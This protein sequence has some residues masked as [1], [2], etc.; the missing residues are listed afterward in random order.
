MNQT[1]VATFTS[2]KD[3]EE[4]VRLLHKEGLPLERF[5]IA[6]TGFNAERQVVGF[7][8]TG[9]V[10]KQGFAR[11]TFAGAELGGLF[12]LLTGAGLFFVPGVGPLLALGGMLVSALSAAATGTLAGAAFGTVAGGLMALGLP[13]N[14][15]LKYETS[16]RSG[17]FLMVTQ[18]TP[19][20]IE[21]VRSLMSHTSATDVEVTSTL[22]AGLARLNTIMSVFAAEAKAARAALQTD[23][24]DQNAA[25][26]AAVEAALVQLRAQ[27]DQAEAQLNETVEDEPSIQAAAEQ[28]RIDLGQARDKLKLAGEQADSGASAQAMIRIEEAEQ[29]LDEAH[30]RLESRLDQSAGGGQQSAPVTPIVPAPQ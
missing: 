15:A 17:N 27:I 25:S 2:N 4:A 22:E 8:Q 21:Q 5:S 30:S 3:A 19:A 13:Q 23:M 10:I 11:G 14:Y 18:G 6:G 20:E 28:A 9:D 29:E 7:V 1:L 12:G 26:R 24:R 16:L